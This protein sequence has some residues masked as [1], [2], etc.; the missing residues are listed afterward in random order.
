[1]TQQPRVRIA[2]NVAI[3]RSFA[4]AAAAVDLLVFPELSLVGYEHDSAAGYVP[5]AAQLQSYAARHAY[6][7][8]MANHAGST[9]G[10]RST[11]RSAIGAPGGALVCAVPGAGNRLVV[12]TWVASSGR[13]KCGRLR[14]PS[15][16]GR[17]AG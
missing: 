16:R 5:D 15:E 7:V 9:G 10:W 17:R 13:A 1:M 2:A 11:G 6:T 3:H 4:Y 14:S 8:L 12:A